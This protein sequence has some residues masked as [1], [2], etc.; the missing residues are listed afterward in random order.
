MRWCTVFRICFVALIATV[1]GY[2]YVIEA[3][4][5]T[6]GSPLG[7]LAVVFL[8]VAVVAALANAHDLAACVERPT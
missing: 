1:P 7:V 6:Y 8:V 3:T 4:W 5:W 2:A